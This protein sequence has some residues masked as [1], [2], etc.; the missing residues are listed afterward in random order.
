M[1]P[2]PYQSFLKRVAKEKQR[3]LENGQQVAKRLE[4]KI[5]IEKRKKQILFEDSQRLE[6]EKILTDQEKQTLRFFE[7]FAKEFFGEFGNIDID[8]N[9]RNSFG[10]V[11]SFADQLEVKGYLL[12]LT[13]QNKTE[14]RKSFLAGLPRIYADKILELNKKDPNYELRYFKYSL[15]C[16]YI[17]NKKYKINMNLNEF[18]YYKL[19]IE[20]KPLFL[21]CLKQE[22][23]EYL[24]FCPIKKGQFSLHSKGLKDSGD[25]YFQ[26]SADYSIEFFNDNQIIEN[27]KNFV[28]KYTNFFVRDRCFIS[29]IN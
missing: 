27:L 2:N 7:S 22:L 8:A 9:L 25:F 1:E 17:L 19:P 14:A 10:K 5:E 11:L 13:E 16:K 6:R 23:E 18:A 24:G 3:S 29:L 26:I 4:L 15:I 28:L 12:D 21:E 20:L